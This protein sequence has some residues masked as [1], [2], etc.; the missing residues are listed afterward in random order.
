MFGVVAG[1]SG[2]QGTIE[3]GGQLF[4]SFAGI[5]NKLKEPEMDRKP[6]L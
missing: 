6:F 3:R 4:A 2:D 1:R 5:V